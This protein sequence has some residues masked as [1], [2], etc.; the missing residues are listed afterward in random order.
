MM[1]SNFS[2]ESEQYDG[3][4]IVTIR[5]DDG[6][7]LDCYVEN[8]V[9]YEGKNYVLLMPIDLT[10][11]ILTDDVLDEEE[12][13]DIETV[14]VEDDDEIDAIF[15]DAKAVLAE[16]NLSLK[17]SGFLLTASGEL[18]PLEDDNLV[19]LELDEDN[20]Q[21]V[22]EELQFLAIF[23]SFEQKY[24]IFTPTTPIMFLGERKSSGKIIIFEPENEKQQAILE[25]LLF[26]SDED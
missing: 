16:L 1:S 8:E 17:R 10:I 15:D 3:T 9:D 5:D 6:R 25:E 19:S 11:M 20:G 13:S 26:E 14:I 4:E 22:G 21:I 18:P 7:C 12:D 23:Y 2:S 24:S